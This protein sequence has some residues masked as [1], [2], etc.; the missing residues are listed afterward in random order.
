MISKVK[1]MVAETGDKKDWF[2]TWFD[3][4]Y[5]H[6]LYKERDEREAEI[7]LDNLLH[8]IHIP[9]GSRILDVACGKGRHSL[10]LN[11]KGYDV[12]GYD[13]SEQSILHN[14]SMENDTLH[15]YLHD[16]REL[17]RTNYFD[18]V[19]N[20]FSSFGYFDKQHDNFR[21]LQSHVSALKKGGLFVL[22]YFNSEKVRSLGDQHYVKNVDGIDFHIDKKL[23]GSRVI[24][25][26]TFN[27]NNEDHQFEEHV[28]LFE[29]KEFQGYFKELG[30]KLLDTYGDYDLNKFDPKASDRMIFLAEKGA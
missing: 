22:D 21:C 2:E 17:F 25:K 28:N 1:P 16:M 15:F 3:S 5:Y 23:S 26:I 4:P 20:L 19:F 14:Q 11:K 29:E 10:Y 7:F 18:A 30:L 9:A 13:L 27:D 8:R 6:V 12:T 24:K